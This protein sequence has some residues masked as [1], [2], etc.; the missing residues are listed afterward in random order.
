M[1]DQCIVLKMLDKTAQ[2]QGQEIINNL[3]HVRTAGY[4]TEIQLILKRHKE[5][6]LSCQDQ[7]LDMHENI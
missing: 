2:T 6:Y 4:E 1:E 3:G 7:K 5:Q